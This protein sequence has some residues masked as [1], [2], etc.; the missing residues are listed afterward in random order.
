MGASYKSNTNN[1]AQLAVTE[2][3]KVQSV[4]I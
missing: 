4:K 3:K 1:T 2:P